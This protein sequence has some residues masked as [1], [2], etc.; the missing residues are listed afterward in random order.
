MAKSN[1][2]VN[3]T[4]KILETTK[5]FTGGLKTV[6][7][8]DSLGSFFLRDVEN[9]SLSEY[10]F[11]EKR[12]GLVDDNDLD[13]SAVIPKLIH[14]FP[15]NK[16]QGYFEYVRPDGFYD[17]ILF[18]NGRLFLARPDNDFNDNPEV[19]DGRF[20]QVRSFAKK[21]DLPAISDELF[22][23]Y[24]ANFILDPTKQTQVQTRVFFDDLF[25][26]VDDIEGVRIGDVLYLFTGVYPIIYEGDGT[27]YLLPEYIPSFN[28]LKFKSHNIHN[29]NNAEYYSKEAARET[30]KDGEFLASF[31]PNVV[32][33]YVDEAVYPRLPFTNQEGTIFTIELAYKLHESL[34]PSDNFTGFL[35]ANDDPKLEGDGGTFAEIVPVHSPHQL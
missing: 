5:Q 6:D 8:D 32:F 31:E 3:T 24:I 1:F 28:E 22:N 4:V 10:G 2:D 21:D 13:L 25:Y 16:V 18:V 29:A 30:L 7:T 26:G 12:Y 17:Q 34:L 9:I 11:L 27:F 20:H 35:D 14:P 15:D 19:I 23:D 33:E